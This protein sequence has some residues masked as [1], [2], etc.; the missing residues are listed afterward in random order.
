MTQMA[1]LVGGGFS[2]LRT[3]KANGELLIFSDD[4]ED[5]FEFRP[6]DAAEIH[7]KPGRKII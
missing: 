5:N 7:L 1:S 4:S 2:Y 3:I 6:A